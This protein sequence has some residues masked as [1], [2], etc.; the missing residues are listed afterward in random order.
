MNP[1]SACSIFA[2]IPYAR[3]PQRGLR[4]DMRVPPGAT[5]PPLV[6]YIP[7]A[8]MR[9][10]AKDRA[11]WW[12]TDSGFAMASIECRVSSE[13]TFPAQVHDCKSAVRWLRA[14]AADYGYRADAIGAWGHSAGGLLAAMLATSGELPSLEGDGSCP[15][16]SSRIQAACDECGAPHDFS[17]FARPDIKTRFAPVAENLRLYLGGPVEEKTELARAASPAAYLSA[18]CPPL[19]LLHGEADTVVPVEETI[20]FHGRL[21]ALGVDATLRVLAGAGHGWDAALTRGEIAAF[22]TRT[23]KTGPRIPN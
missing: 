20:E 2:D 6:L 14:H 1:P 11:P 7:M 4:L 18:Q 23:L 17:W 12:L 15:G 13:A 16:V 10:C 19:L 5:P 3:T 21:K 22:F 9:G 8:G